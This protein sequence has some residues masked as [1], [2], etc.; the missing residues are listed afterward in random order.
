[1]TQQ[2][3]AIVKEAHAPSPEDEKQESEA[4][5]ILAQIVGAQMS[6]KALS[7]KA[8]IAVSHLVSLIAL[9]TVFAAWLYILNAPTMNQLIGCGVYSAFV[10]VAEWVRRK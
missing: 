1:M 4:R 8:A 6:I 5:D 9:G 7:M 2:S 3:F 10:L